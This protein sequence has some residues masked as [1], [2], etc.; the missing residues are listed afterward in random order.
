MSESDAINVLNNLGYK[1]IQINRVIS[2]EP[3]GTVISQ[4]P[5]YSSAP[6]VDLATTIVLTVS[7]G[8]TDNTPPVEDTTDEFDDI[9]DME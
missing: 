4:S 1:T 6:H 9:E 8:L 3:V 7:K 5:T 2:A